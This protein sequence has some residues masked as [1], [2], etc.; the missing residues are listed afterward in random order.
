MTSR[1]CFSSALVCFFLAAAPEGVSGGWLDPRFDLAGANGTI[2]SLVEFRGALYA[3]GGFT[4]IG[5][6]QAPG[7][8]RWSGSKWEAIQPGLNASVT[9]A[10]ATDEAMYFATYLSQL[11]QPAGLLRWDGQTWTAL[12]TPPGFRDVLGVP[13]LTNGRDIYV[14]A[15]PDTSVGG[16]YWFKA[17]TK[18][19]GTR[20]FV[21]ADTSSI[22]GSGLN[23]L[24]IAQGSIYGS[25]VFYD[26]GNTQ[27][28]LNLGRLAPPNWVPVGGGVDMGY[29]VFDVASDGTNLLIQGVFRTVGSQAADGFAVWDGSQWF[30]PTADSRG[31]ARVAA[32]SSNPGKVLANEVLSTNGPLGER[33]ISQHLVQYVG[34]NRTVLTRGD[35][36]GMRLMR[37]TT[38]G[39]LSAGYR[40]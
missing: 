39:T 17:L 37:R 18:W 33:L 24:T 15:F 25:G 6:V 2:T 8:A 13:M 14:E 26:S 16:P 21:L 38:F 4:R 1:R 10:V 31:G 23:G 34:T 36:P 7:V 20:W 29:S 22:G 28:G 40:L 30:A 27:Q 9:S 5:G 32:L 35:A 19:D 11:N 3:V 12:G